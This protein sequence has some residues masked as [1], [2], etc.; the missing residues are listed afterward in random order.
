MKYFKNAEC[1]EDVKKMFKEYVKEL[2]PDNGGDAEAF[3]DMMSEY[4]DAF[5]RYKDIHRNVDGETYE[6][7]E[8]ST[9]TPEQFADIINKVVWMEGV[10]IEIIG[11]WVW[12]SGN[13]MQYKDDIRS[14]GFFWSKSKKAWYYTGESKKSKRRGRYSMNKLREKWGTTEVKHATTKRIAYA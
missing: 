7:E 1:I 9:E 4:N 14:A 10:T 13:T 12:L 5:N 3:K 11:S 8:K 6:R 2:H